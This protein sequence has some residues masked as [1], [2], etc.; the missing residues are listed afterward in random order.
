MYESLADILRTCSKSPLDTKQLRDARGGAWL[1]HSLHLSGLELTAFTKKY[2]VRNRTRSNL[3][4]K[5]Q[6]GEAAPSELTVATVEESLPGSRWIYDLPLW[7]LL[8]NEPISSQRLRTIAAGLTANPGIHMWWFPGDD[9]R[10]AQAKIP[11][12]TYPDTDPLVARNDVW[13]LV[14]C[15]L[16][17]RLCEQDR[18]MGEHLNESMNMF[19]ALPGALKTPGFRP[20]AQ[21]L[22]SSLMDLR[23]RVFLSTLLYD[24][25]LDVILR[26]ADDPTHQP[27]RDFFKRDP[28]TDRIIDIEDPILF[29]DIVPGRVARDR[30][31]RALASRASRGNRTSG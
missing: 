3:V 1:G 30:A 13:G 31:A 17:T 27:W 5:W 7:E 18:A 10:F 4:R 20:Y 21:E 26:Q 12:A 23:S 9:A 2:I 15:V 29:A 28:Q 22:F 8:R 11:F 19:R 14:G 24:V 6:R 16:K 25:D